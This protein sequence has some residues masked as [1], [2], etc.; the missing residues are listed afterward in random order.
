MI[1]LSAPNGMF[2]LELHESLWRGLTSAVALSPHGSLTAAQAPALIAWANTLPELSQRADLV[3]ALAAL[4]RCAG[5][6]HV[7]RRP[8][9]S[10]ERPHA[11][12]PT[13]FWE[14]VG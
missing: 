4:L 7:L 2:T 11:T 12:P 6:L 1:R 10:G 14:A 5:E 9:T 8:R 3:R 13:S